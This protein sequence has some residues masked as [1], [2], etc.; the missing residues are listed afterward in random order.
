M[1]RGIV[2]SVN[3]NFMEVSI[4]PDNELVRY[5]YRQERNLILKA[6]MLIEF[7]VNRKSAAT[8]IKILEQTQQ[9]QRIQQTHPTHPHL[10]HRTQTDPERPN[11]QR[12]N[13]VTTH[14]AVAVEISSQNTEDRSGYRFLNPYNFVRNLPKQN[15]SFFARQTP[16]SHDIYRELTGYLDCDIDVFTPLFISSGKPV[17]DQ[18]H[19]GYDFSNITNNK[20]EKRKVIPGSSLRG[21]VRSI[22]ETIT[23]SCYAVFDDVSLSRRMDATEGRYLSPARV[24]HQ[25]GKWQL[26]MFNG[27]Q[28]AALRLMKAAWISLY[29][30]ISGAPQRRRLKISLK[31]F[32]HGDPAWAV[33]EP[34]QLKSSLYIWNVLEL[35]ENKEAAELFK[36]ENQGNTN[37]GNTIVEYGWV[38]ITRQNTERKHDERFFFGNSQIVE[39]SERVLND[40][41]KVVEDYQ[42]R[43]HE[44]IDAECQANTITEIS[45]RNRTP[46][47]SRF[48]IQDNGGLENG[49]LV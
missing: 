45:A 16:P 14:Q 1:K 2:K 34:H 46:R 20:N 15:A 25:D 17:S 40:Y 21:M 47:L 24:I 33:L 43:H 32:K 38:C 31:K 18:V 41:R 36:S 8:D 19:P 35:F 39:L 9:T 29:D 10:S 7:E 48:I 4:Q 13:D 37:Q 26:E 22:Y 44:E 28:S 12:Q 42:L 30:P 3:F 6:G 27:R 23:G 11:I 49:D 5:T